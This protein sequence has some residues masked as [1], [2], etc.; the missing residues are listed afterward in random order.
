MAEKAKLGGSFIGILFLALGIFKFLQGDDWIVWII[1]GV[2]F[3]G[4]GV[5]AGK[6]SGSD[7][8]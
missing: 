4:L 3:G 1:L 7:E 8:A 5:F 2:L 6:R